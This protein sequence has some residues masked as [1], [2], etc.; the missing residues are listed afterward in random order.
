VNETGSVKFS[1]DQVTTEIPEFAGFAALN[2]YR[3]QLVELGL[4]GV[5]ANGIGFGN[6][7]LRDGASSQFYIT[8]SGT[9]GILELT[10]AD[11][12]KVAAYDFGKNWLRYEGRTM[13]SSE[14]LTHAAVYE[15]DPT[16]RAVIHCHDLKL[17]SAFLDKVPT[18][19]TSVEYGIPEMAFAVKRLF[20]TTDVKTKNIFVMG[21]HEGGI[22]G[23]GKSMEAAYIAIAR[24]KEAAFK[25]SRR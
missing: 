18:T 21:G 1:C 16:A 25:L 3:R 2:K 23:F 22:V 20:E 9:G 19:P 7:S 13:A 12:A 11:C 5:D 4:I 10:S 14:S 15:S 17:W 24:A 6:I 8:G